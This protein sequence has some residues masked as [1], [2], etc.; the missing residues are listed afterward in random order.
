MQQPY[1]PAKCTLVH[2][3]REIKIYF[4]TQKFCTWI[5]IVA[6]FIMT[7]NWKQHRCP[8]TGESLHNTYHGIL[9][10]NNNKCTI[11]KHNKLD[12]FPDN[13]V[14]WKKPLLNAQILYNSIY[15]TFLKGYNYRHREE[16]S[17]CQAWEIGI[18]EVSMPLKEQQ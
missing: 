12:Q 17:G 15:K 5:F 3:Y 14:E 8:S 4:Y 2:C 16:I 7:P 18:W 1:D 13:S 10:G 9:P 11:N 6:L